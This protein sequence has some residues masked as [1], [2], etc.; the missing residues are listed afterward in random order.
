MFSV[1]EIAVYFLARLQPADQDFIVKPKETERKRIK[2][3]K[4]MICLSKIC[5]DFPYYLTLLIN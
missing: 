1:M 4:L 2:I 3:I 5:V